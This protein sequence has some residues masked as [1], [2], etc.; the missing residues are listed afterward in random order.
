MRSVL[1]NRNA[2]NWNGSPQRQYSL[3]VRTSLAS[4]SQVMIATISLLLFLVS[5][6]LAIPQNLAVGKHDLI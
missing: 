4:T 2:L 1:F 6:E 5:A 3:T